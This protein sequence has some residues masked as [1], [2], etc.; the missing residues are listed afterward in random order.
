MK[1]FA[2]LQPEWPLFFEAATKAEGLANSDARASCFYARRTLELA[3]AWM[4]AHDHSL[5][6]PYQDNLSAFIGM[7]RRRLR[8]RVVRRYAQRATRVRDLLD[9]L[10]RGYP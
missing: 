4:Y 1:N 2:F 9:S 5:R 8:C 6:R 7:T 10:Y 3:V